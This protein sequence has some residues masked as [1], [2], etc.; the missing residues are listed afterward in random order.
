MTNKDILILL[1]LTEIASQC[2]DH[3]TM[4][5]DEFRGFFDGCD[6]DKLELQLGELKKCGIGRVE[7][8]AKRIWKYD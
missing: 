7:N 5:V 2:I 3:E 6:Q 8:H 4:S 1:G